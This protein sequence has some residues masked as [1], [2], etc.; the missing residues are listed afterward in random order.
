MRSL[1]AR[2]D[3]VVIPF[4][5]RWGV[6][7]LRISLAIVFIWFGTL[8]VLGISPVVELIAS[9]VYWV[10]SDWFVPALGVV[11]ILVGLGL[12]LRRWLRTVLLV[13]AGQIVGT[14]LV[15]ILLPDIAFQDG[16]PLKL[17][18]E[19]EFVI[20]NLVLL[21]AGMMIGASIGRSEA[22]VPLPTEESAEI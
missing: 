2:V 21:G 6:P 18:V 16:N 9:L 10:D 5:R 7:T 4:L 17:T 12:A 19:G 20:K 11:E 15:F 22:V 8:K 1:V 13:L 14:F 3:Q